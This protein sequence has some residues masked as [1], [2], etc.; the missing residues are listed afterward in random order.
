MSRTAE[1]I[2][3]RQVARI[4]SRDVYGT[5]STADWVKALN[6]DMILEILGDESYVDYLTADEQALLQGKIIIMSE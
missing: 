2:H 4:A 6:K 5:V 1:E 3:Y